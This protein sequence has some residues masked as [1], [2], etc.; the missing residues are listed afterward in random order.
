[1]KTVK[2]MLGLMVVTAAGV[3]SAQV[4]IYT[5]TT[6]TV[7]RAPTVVV[8]AVAPAAPVFVAPAPVVVYQRPVCVA[9]PPVVVVPPPALCVPPLPAIRIGLGFGLGWGYAHGHRYHG[10]PAHGYHGHHHR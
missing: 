6:V 5:K 8:A 1:M 2:A 9:P 3:A 4:P 7:H 10:W